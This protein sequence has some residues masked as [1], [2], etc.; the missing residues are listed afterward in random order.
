MVGMPCLTDGD[1]NRWFCVLMLSMH[2][3]L[4]R[5]WRASDKVFFCSLW[6]Y[7]FGF[8]TSVGYMAAYGSFFSFLLSWCLLLLAFLS[9]YWY[10]L[11]D[12]DR[13][14]QP[15]RTRLCLYVCVFFCYY[16]QFWL[17]SPFALSFAAYVFLPSRAWP[18]CTFTLVQGMR[19]FCVMGYASVFDK[20]WIK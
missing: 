14:D 8:C 19:V 11:L 3:V 10:S 1:K 6:W 9:F 13:S 2:V 7:M 15:W 16:V 17:S 5:Q 18:K 4:A 12:M 20:L